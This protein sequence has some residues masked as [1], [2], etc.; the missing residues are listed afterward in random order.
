MIR[1]GSNASALR[2]INQLNKITRNIEHTT[3]VISSGKRIMTAKDDPAGFVQAM[4]MRSD[5]G[6][7]NVVN[8]NISNGI[9]L[10]K[11]TES[12]LSGGI[13]ILQEMKNLSIESKNGTLSTDQRNALQISFKELQKQYDETINGSELF[14][15]NLLNGSM[16]DIKIQT[17]KSASGH[18]SINALDSS[19][20]T[21]G[22]DST[23]IN[24]ST[25]IDS[26]A[27]I[28]AIDDAIN[29]LSINQ[30]I[31]GSTQKGLETRKNIVNNYLENLTSSLSRVEDADMG[32]EIANLKLMQVQQQMAMES[33]KII[34]Q[35]PSLALQLIR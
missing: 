27:S 10:M 30:S 14:G 17:G 11:M 1:T 35:M 32:K 4:Y 33:L 26:D 28:T 3:K 24:I 18:R 16:T 15:K 34:M 25:A 6:S 22:T 13:G 20:I 8:K 2:A 31:Y 12:G 21:L 7:Y 29:K 23:T 9:S 19:S 5:I